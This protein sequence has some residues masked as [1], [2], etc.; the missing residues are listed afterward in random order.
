MG[1]IKDK[2]ILIGSNFT[3]DNYYTENSYY[4]TVDKTSFPTTS[5]DIQVHS[6][7]PIFYSINNVL[8]K[9]LDNDKYI[10][11]YLDVLS[12]TQVDR[13]KLVNAY[14]EDI[15]RV[16]SDIFE[17]A[18]IAHQ[19]DYHD[20]AE[21]RFEDID[22]DYMKRDLS[23]FNEVEVRKN[24]L[25]GDSDIEHGKDV[26]HLSSASVSADVVID[27]EFND[28]TV[29]SSSFVLAS[30]CNEKTSY[31]FK[32]EMPASKSGMVTDAVPT[33]TNIPYIY[34][35][36]LSGIKEFFIYLPT[37]FT[38]YHEHNGIVQS[39]SQDLNK[40]ATFIQIRLNK[41]HFDLHHIYSANIC[42][43][44][45]PMQIHMDK[46]DRFTDVIQPSMVRTLP[47]SVRTEDNADCIYSKN[48]NYFEM[49]FTCY[50]TDAQAIRLMCD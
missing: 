12:S 40:D 25:S 32:Y 23:N 19:I 43:E 34:R 14:K 4:K 31:K 48:T 17:K 1:L 50:G 29:K 44:S 13:A 16:S 24:L 6:N 20:N 37:T 9:L 30:V 5:A 42:G 18:V 2:K 28:S 47:I 38:F 11:R 33:L 15:T 49:I 8:N 39:P 3:H 22:R 35:R 27:V 36:W 10:N 46:D 41:R 21:I 7:Q 26:I 45:L